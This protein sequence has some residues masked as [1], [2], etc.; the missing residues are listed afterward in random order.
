[1]SRNNAKKKKQQKRR[2]QQHINRLRNVTKS[3]GGPRSQ[4]VRRNSAKTRG[5]QKSRNISI[6]SSNHRRGGNVPPLTRFHQRLSAKLGFGR[7]KL[8]NGGGDPVPIVHQWEDEADLDLRMG[9]QEK[10]T[11]DGVS[12]S[13]TD[14]L[15]K[16]D[17]YP[18]QAGPTYQPTQEGDVLFKI[19]LSPLN[20][21]ATRI[22]ELALM[23]QRYKVP[24]LYVHLVPTT[25]AFQSG[26]VIPVIMY[27]PD[28]SLT[29]YGG[30]DKR[31]RMAMSMYDSTMINVYQPVTVGAPG[32][33]NETM[34]TRAE[35]ADARLVIPGS[36]C[37]IAASSFIPF[38]GTPETL[39]LY[40]VYI[41]YRYD[42]TVRGLSVPEPILP[43]ITQA[44]TATTLDT[45]FYFEGA[46]STSIGYPVCLR[47]NF[48]SP[49]YKTLQYVYECV[50]VSLAGKF[51]W[52]SD[53][54]VQY[55][56]LTDGATDTFLMSNGSPIYMFLDEAN[57]L[58]G[59]CYS[60]ATNLTAAL[61]RRSDLF[62]GSVDLVSTLSSVGLQI[63]P[64]TVS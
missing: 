58:G 57:S 36:F 4:P 16:I 25:N 56:F 2:I 64:V 28:I 6:T 27:D 46:L 15:G 45:I 3:R 34:W 42:F 31:V 61:E 19:P 40:N 41:S 48:I 1:M 59:A 63:N 60:F 22:Q 24:E 37:V 26:S 62:W 39:T 29:E 50:V 20:L 55:Q 10:S 21:Q 35:D 44:V 8:R 5:K 49:V 12:I 54:G 52:Q 47:D 11:F 14:Y 33:F 17:V 53:G 18:T 43:G 51:G 30:D 7:R 38:T 23:Y 32:H 13:G 9:Q